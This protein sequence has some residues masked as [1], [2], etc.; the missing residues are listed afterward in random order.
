MIKDPFIIYVRARDKKDKKRAQS[1]SCV[2]RQLC[3]AHIFLTPWD[4]LGLHGK[5]CVCNTRLCDKS[6][7]IPGALVL[8][9]GD[10]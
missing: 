2:L 8:L 5:G 9:F 3:R 6:G 10:R 4:S 7:G 1:L